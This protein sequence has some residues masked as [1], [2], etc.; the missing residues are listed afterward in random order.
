M[1]SVAAAVHPSLLWL[2]L[3]AVT[4]WAV[5]KL[6]PMYTVRVRWVQYRQTVIVIVGCCE[7]AS[8]K[9]TPTVLPRPTQPRC[10]C[11]LAAAS[12]WLCR[13]PSLPVSVYFRLV[14]CPY[15]RLG[16]QWAGQY[17][18]L[19]AHESSCAQPHKTGAEL[20]EPLR[21]IEEAKQ[22]EVKQYKMILDLM[23]CEKV[24]ITGM[25]SRTLKSFFS[26]CLCNEL[27]SCDTSR[28]R[29]RWIE[30]CFCCCNVTRVYLPV[31]CDR[32][33][34]LLCGSPWWNFHSA[35]MLSGPTK[36]FLCLWHRVF[37]LFMLLSVCLSVCLS[38]RLKR[39]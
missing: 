4:E 12:L 33:W 10:W 19:S 27:S 1:S 6:V 7:N 5:G 26:F 3:L 34:C 37:G 23:S 38:V 13:N 39:C 16:C 25:L 15:T 14:R 31:F 2:H 18:K 9:G 30:S 24:V 21:V 32:Q 22:E 20:I 17:H 8:S 35:K 29:A 28:P 36:L 11:S